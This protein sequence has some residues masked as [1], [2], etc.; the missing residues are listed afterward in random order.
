[1]CGRENGAEALL[2]RETG[3]P[4]FMSYHCLVHQQALCSKQ[5]NLKKVMN[6]VVEIVCFIRARALNHRQFKELLIE[7]QSEHSDVLLHAEI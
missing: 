2:R 3:F 4:N 5:A 1:M 6:T 7:L